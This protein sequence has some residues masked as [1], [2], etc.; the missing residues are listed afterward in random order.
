MNRTDY[1][2]GPTFD[3]VAKITQHLPRNMEHRRFQ[4][5]VASGTL[6]TILGA[7]PDHHI[8]DDLIR[9]INGEAIVSIAKQLTVVSSGRTGRDWIDFFDG[10]VSDV[11]KE[12]L[13]SDQFVSTN[14]TKYYLQ[15][16]PGRMRNHGNRS[17]QAV[18]FGPEQAKPVEMG[19]EMACLIQE[20][21]SPADLSNTDRGVLAVHR[22]G[23][24]EEIITLFKRGHYLIAK[25]PSEN[26]SDVPF[27]SAKTIS[28]THSLDGI[29]THMYCRNITGGE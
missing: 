18:R 6:Q 24:D 9:V 16:A 22:L 20:Q 2:H 7:L 21:L 10:R 15:H 14:G 25:W 12:I 28:D 19:L 4:E 3:A 23:T 27:L 11:A 1:F 8:V 29:S 26:E 5:L 17:I 13:L